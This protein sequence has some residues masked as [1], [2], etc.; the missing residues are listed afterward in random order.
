MIYDVPIL[1]GVEVTPQ[2]IHM[3]AKEDVIHS[4]KWS[5]VEVSRIHDT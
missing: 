1:A 4:V 3:L 5:H 2:E